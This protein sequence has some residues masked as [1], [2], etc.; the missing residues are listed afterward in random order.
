M[1]RRQVWSIDHAQ[2]RTKEPEKAKDVRGLTED[3]GPQ[4]RRLGDILL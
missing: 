4:Q 3:L 2:R 1:N